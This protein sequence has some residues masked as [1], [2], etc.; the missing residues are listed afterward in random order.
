MSMASS[1]SFYEESSWGKRV[2]EKVLSFYAS[3]PKKGKPQGRE[4]TVLAAFLLSSPSND[5]KVVAMGTGTKCIGRSLLRTCGDVV[6]DSHAE[7]IARRAL[8]R[9]FYTQIQHLTESSSKHAPGNGGKRFKLD[10]DHLPFEWDPGCL[11]KGK[12]TLKKDWKLHMYISQLPCG[13]ASLSFHVSPLET[14]V[15]GESDSTSPLDNGSKQKGMVQRKPGRGDTTLSVSCSDKIARWNVVGVQGALLSYFLQPVYLSSITVGLPL[16]IP[17]NFRL[18]D[19]LKRALYERIPPLLNELTSP[20]LVNQPIFHAA[21]VP[22]KDFQQSESAAN[23]LTCGYSIGWN[24]CG[25]HDIIMGT[26]GRKQGTSAKGALYPSTQSSLCKKRLLEVFLSLR[27]ENLISSLPNGI[28]YRELK[29]GAEEYH[30]A[31]KI[32]KGKP[33]FNKWFLKPLDCEAFH[34]SE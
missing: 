11:N 25:L 8:M 2:S 7:V 20:F 27:P 19:N 29:D 15:L 32:F 21:P 5:L 6:H 34:I 9:F 18:E 1:V 4:V 12:Y 31:S 13:D 3:L 23:T 10:E 30:L 22:P 17:E 14:V 16:N 28:T 33:P 24:E 26:T